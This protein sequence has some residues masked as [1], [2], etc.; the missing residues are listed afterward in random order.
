MLKTTMSLFEGL[1]RH[2]FWKSRAFHLAAF[3]LIWLFIFR[4]YLLHRNTVNMD[5]LLTYGVGK[6][7]LNN[8]LNGVVPLW[9]PFT[10]LGAPY[11][12]LGILGVFS[13]VFIIFPLLVLIGVSYY[14]AFLIYSILNF[15]VGC[16]GFYFLA[17]AF[18]KDEVFALL[19]FIA[20]LFSSV[21]LLLFVQANMILMFTPAM[22]VFYF[23]L[24]FLERFRTADFLGLV[25]CTMV[26]MTSYLP[27]HFIT[28]LI[29]LAV[30]ASGIYWRDL[31]RV[32]KGCVD[33]IRKNGVLVIVAA[34]GIVISAMPLIQQKIA[35]SRGEIVAPARH[36]NYK[37]N[38]EC[39]RDTMKSET[40]MTRQE[41]VRSGTLDERVSFARLFSHLD[42]LSSG[43]DGILYIPTLCYLLAL[44]GA[45]IRI[46]RQSG[47]LLFALLIIGMLALGDNASLYGFF[48]E[49]IFFFKYFR[50]MFYFMIFLIPLLILFAAERVR[51]V[52]ESLA[53]DPASGRWILGG[54]VILT[55]GFGAFLFF[56]GNILWTTW[57]T[58]LG[59]LLCAAALL[60][61]PGLRWKSAGVMGIFLVF[62]FIEPIQVLSAYSEHARPYAC[63]LPAQHV[64]PVMAFTR[65]DGPVET[66]CLADKFLSVVQDI[67][68]DMLLTD[69]D[70]T[71]G[72]PGT[73]GRGT[74]LL[75]AY[76]QEDDLKRYTHH[77]FM[78]Y[79]QVEP[80]AATLEN[81][82]KVVGSVKDG[83]DIVY[84]S[85]SDQE[86]L[87]AFPSAG[88]L[89][90][91]HGM[92][93]VSQPGENFRVSRFDVNGL[94]L[95]TNYPEDQFLVYTDS[96]DPAWQVFINGRRARLYKANWAFK[97][98]WLPRGHNY[99][100]LHYEPWGGTTIYVFVTL[101]FIA[102]GTFTVRKLLFQGLRT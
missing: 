41:V 54:S 37:S 62:L 50:N 28:V 32:G 90:A 36:C 76:I 85:N 11:Y 40:A 19:A 13:P 63:Q 93:P 20:L 72:M 91:R 43:T 94:A 12:S 22:W 100:E 83:E 7:F 77:K 89:S 82:A 97:G 33:F 8:L 31:G 61:K 92:A 98:I 18:L 81:L 68:H 46:N 38:E 79:R 4:D 14:D 96:Y 88:P 16:L 57:T 58:L 56:Q 52:K 47:L 75:S 45:F 39:L 1:L 71:I 80:L 101:F 21:G 24:R 42:K 60:I 23:L 44:C 67:W 29:V 2:K 51:S 27:F 9:D 70:G 99:V 3:F 15:W 10:H 17:R 86:L 87:R 30:L 73:V 66:G 25:F 26:L 53:Q 65:A 34:A 84:V 102:F 48:Y 59:G 78:L 64:R 35:D 74:F 5:T 49:H 69:T 6:F 55:L 95:L